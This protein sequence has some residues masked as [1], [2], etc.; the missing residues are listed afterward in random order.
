MTDRVIKD[1]IDTNDFSA[2]QL[3]EMVALIALLKDADRDGCG[4]GLLARRSLGMISEVPPAMA[5]V[6]FEAAMVKLG[7]HALC[8]GPGEIRLGTRESLGDT[9]RLLS[10]LCDVI[11]ARVLR[12]Q[13]V[14]DLAAQASVPVINGLSDYNHPSQAL[15]DLFTMSEHLP[16]GKSLDECRVV[17]VGGATSVCS[18][19][20]H[21]TTKFGMRFTHAGPAAYQAPPAWLKRAEE[22]IAA[23]GHGSVTVTDEVEYAV[24]DADFL[25][26][27]V[28]WQVGREDEIPARTAA[29]MPRYQ[30]NGALL[31][32]APRAAFMHCLPA[33]PGAEVTGDVIGSPRSIVFDQAENRLHTQKALLAWFTYPRVPH[34]PPSGPR[35]GHEAAIR[36][37]IAGRRPAWAGGAPAGAPSRARSAITTGAFGR[38]AGPFL[39][40]AARWPARGWNGVGAASDHDGADAGCHDWSAGIPPAVRPR[41]GDHANQCPEQLGYRR[42]RPSR[43]RRH[44]GNGAPAARWRLDGL[45]RRHRGHRLA[46]GHGLTRPARRRRDPAM[47]RSVAAP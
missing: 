16:P 25:Y 45:A 1:F 5:P 21:I 30:V 18:S 47:G 2:G 15:A 6:S 14:L 37:F 7:G 46:A 11:E 10:R 36:E 43:A 20:M 32:R 33:A 39:P 38:R 9:A 41:S 22:N 28:W 26:A 13:T 44:N 35:T 4:P 31:A 40:T 29:F 27:D 17:F 23:A 24:A 42:R 19:L 12:H 8:L 3:T 34:D